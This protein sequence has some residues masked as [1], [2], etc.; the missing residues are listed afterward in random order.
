MRG[1]KIDDFPPASMVACCTRR[2]VVE[3]NQPQRSQALEVGVERPHERVD[4][5]R[6]RGNQE[7]RYSKPVASIGR[8]FDPSFN[9][10]PRVLRGHDDWKSR[11]GALEGH[12]VLAGHAGQELEA[13]RLGEHGFVR[14]NQR[15]ERLRH[16][17]GRFTRR[18]H[19]HRGVDDDHARRRSFFRSSVGS[20]SNW[21]LPT[22]AFNS[23]A[24]LR[25]TTSRRAWTTVSV[26]DRKPRAVRASSKSVTGK[27]RVVRIQTSL[28]DMAMSHQ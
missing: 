22:R 23:S 10:P 25:R 11:Q 27:W 21:T 8:R 24:R 3:P 16:V 2:L 6:E 12:S 9:E 13:N 17:R 19:P 1:W 28:F 5:E 26:F 4:V 7:V 20:N 18:S 14:V 15:A